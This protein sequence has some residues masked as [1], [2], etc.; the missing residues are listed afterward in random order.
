MMNVAILPICF[1]DTKET[2]QIYGYGICPIM[3]RINKYYY[4]KLYIEKFDYKGLPS[5]ATCD[6]HQTSILILSLEQV[7]Y[8]FL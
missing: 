1:T 5:G 2:Y 7:P 8:R 4:Y 6:T 3:Q